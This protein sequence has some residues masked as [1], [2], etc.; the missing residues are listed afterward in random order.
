MPDFRVTNFTIRVNTYSS[1]QKTSV[2]S[3]S[4]E[5]VC[6]NGRGQDSGTWWNAF[7]KIP[8]LFSNAMPLCCCRGMVL[9]SNE[10][11][12]C[13]FLVTEFQTGI[14]GSILQHQGQFVHVI[15]EWLYEDY[16]ALSICFLGCQYIPVG[17]PHKPSTREMI[18]K[19]IASTVGNSYIL[20]LDLAEE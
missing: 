20:T 11:C 17:F 19:R 12:T 13:S 4:W 2:S 9:I 15:T 6:K 7:D 3:Q 5:G 8:Q 16:T 1:W 18:V 14:G 10:P